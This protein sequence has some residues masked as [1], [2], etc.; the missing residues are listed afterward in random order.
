MENDDLAIR[1]AIKTTVNRSLDQIRIV[2]IKHTLHIETMDI[3]ENLISEIAER[4][5]IEIISDPYNY[6]FDDEGNLLDSFESV[7]E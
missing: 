1:A 4:N 6:Q 2:R 7:S 3:S 5:D